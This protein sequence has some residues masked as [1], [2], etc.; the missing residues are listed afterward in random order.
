MIASRGHGAAVAQLREA[1]TDDF[2]LGFHFATEDIPSLDISIALGP[3]PS[4]GSYSSE[5]SLAWS[6][7]GLTAANCVYSAG[8]ESVP[9]GSFQ[10][11]L[12][13]LEIA[14]GGAGGAAGANAGAGAEALAANGGEAGSDA[15]SES[16]P[17]AGSFHGTLRLTMYVEAP[18]ATD[19]G[20]GNTENLVV[21]F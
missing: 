8:S 18:A 19:C 15:G 7:A 13:S 12:S 11:T 17:R 4:A 21:D 20:I 2:A 9:V 1:G 5:G 3:S 16:E 14:D 6:A 10:L